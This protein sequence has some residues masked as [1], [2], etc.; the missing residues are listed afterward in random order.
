MIHIGISSTFGKKWL[1]DHACGDA[2]GKKRLFLKFHENINTELI[3]AN[4]K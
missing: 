4:C 1:D 3:G 2:L